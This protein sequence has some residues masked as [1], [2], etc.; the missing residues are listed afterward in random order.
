MTKKFHISTIIRITTAV[1]IVT[2]L[3]TSQT[4]PTLAQEETESAS[5]STKDSLKDRIDKVVEEKKEQVK[6]KVQEM[7]Q[8]KRGFI[9]RV[10]RVSK[11]SITLENRKGVQVIP[12][13]ETLS[14]IKDEEP[15]EIEDI[16]VD[17]WATVL[18]YQLEENEFEAVKLVVNEDRLNPQPQI[19]EIGSVTD[20]DSEQITIKTRQDGTEIK[21]ELSTQTVLED[22]NQQEIAVTDLFEEMQCLIAGYKEIDEDDNETNVALTVR[23]L[24]PIKSD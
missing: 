3:A 7:T 15:I 5:P 12:L 18:G 10:D 6:N 14:L 2:F 21:F 11:E 20:Y 4:L 19:V 23:S 17:N 22:L 8:K 24:A 13:Q 16:A 9:G 1:V